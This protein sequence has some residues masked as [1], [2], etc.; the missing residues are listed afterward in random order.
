M[1]MVE[2]QIVKRFTDHRGFVFEPIEEKWIAKQKNVH[3][4]VSRPGAV[5]GNHY[6]ITGTETLIVCGPALVS[7]R[8]GNQREAFSIPA[9]KTFRMVIPP[10][11]SHAIQN[12][13]D[14]DSLLVAFN[15]N[16]HDPANPDTVQDIL[17]PVD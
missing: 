3:V 6:H 8:H 10:G 11:I 16:S 14:V 15:T 2:K 5:R 13:G 7:L 12:I 9:D 17:I 4:V 1:K